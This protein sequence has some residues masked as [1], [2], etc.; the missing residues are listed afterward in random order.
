MEKKNVAAKVRVA[1][2]AVKT[3]P[4][5]HPAFQA[6]ALDSRLNP[7]EYVKNF[8]APGGGE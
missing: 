2:K 1:P 8:T 6:I 5:I 7:K 4:G 3:A